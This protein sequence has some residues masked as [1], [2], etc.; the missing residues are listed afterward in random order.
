MSN[1]SRLGLIALAIAVAVVAFVVLSPGD[2]DEKADDPATTA[3]H[4]PSTDDP[5]GDRAV[6]AGARR[7]RDRGE[8]RKAGGRRAEGRGEEGRHRA[9][10][11]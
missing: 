8:G 6:G 10:R 11:W 3:E 4:A 7:R 5:R 2:T 1:R 9:A